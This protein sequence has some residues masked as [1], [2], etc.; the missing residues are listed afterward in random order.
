MH[1][2]AKDPRREEMRIKFLRE[3]GFSLVE[4][5]VVLAVICILG[6]MAVIGTVGAMQSSKAN[7]AMDAVVTVLRSGRQLAIT[8]RRNVLVTFT[9]PN[10]IQLAV[11]TLPGETLVAP[12]A[13]VYL[14]DNAKNGLQF[15][16]LVPNDVP[17]GV[18]NS[19]PINLVNT[20]GA[21]SPAAVMFNSSG[22]FVG[23]INLSSYATVGNND[24]VNGTVFLGL[25]G[26]LRTARAVTILGSTGRVRTYTWAGSAGWQEQ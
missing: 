14:N 16:V 24:P 23:S 20:T 6:A 18:G 5:M 12:A 21:G 17:G 26:D 13:P 2:S 1:P 3:R 22:T 9:A 15:A 7:N 25:P 11:Q 8:K 4:L 10:R 19:Q